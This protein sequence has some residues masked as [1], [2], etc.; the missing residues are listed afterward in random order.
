MIIIDSCQEDYI[1]YSKT[2]VDNSQKTLKN[3]KEE[4]VDN[5]E[6]LKFVIEIKI[7]I[8]EDRYNFN[9]R[10]K[11]DYPEKIEKLEEDSFN[12]TGQNVLRIL[13][14]EFPDN[15]WKYLTKKLK[16]P[17]ECFKSLHDYKKPA[18][19]LEKKDFFSNLK[20]CPDDKEIERTMELIKKFNI[21]S[22][23]E[24]TRIYLKSDVFI[25]CLCFWELFKSIL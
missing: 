13:K 2:Q 14:T 19:K 16:H 10:L 15:K 6:L 20:K 8:K 25:S 21:K 9:W 12:Y 23:E 3:S 17:Y 18:D 1:N 11:K 4:F 22:G 24:L 5:D 7:L